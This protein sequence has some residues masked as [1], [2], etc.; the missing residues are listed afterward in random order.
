[1]YMPIGKTVVGVGLRGR[2][3]VAEHVILTSADY[4]AY[5]L[6]NAF[7]EFKNGAFWGPNGCAQGARCVVDVWEAAQAAKGGDK[8]ED[9]GPYFK[10]IDLEGVLPA[11]LMEAVR[12]LH[13]LIATTDDLLLHHPPITG[14]T[15]NR[16]SPQTCCQSDRGL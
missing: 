8:S 16:V 12:T 11:N 9:L 3:D 14:I 6:S 7:G 13:K 4:T 2:K 5:S 15:G 10:D 1:M